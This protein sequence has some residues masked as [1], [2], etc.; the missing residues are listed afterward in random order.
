MAAA[1]R[2]RARGADPPR[3]RISPARRRATAAPPEALVPAQPCLICLD[4]AGTSRSACGHAFC[5]PCWEHYLEGR[6]SE[7][8]VLNMPCPASSHEPGVP[9]CPGVT[10]A[11]VA[12]V[13]PAAMLSRFDDFMV[14]E[15]AERDPQ[16]R[17]CTRPGCGSICLPWVVED[18]FSWR[19]VAA[20]IL[21]STAA[22]A[23]PLR[24]PALCTA[25]RLTPWVAAGTCALGVLGFIAAL[26]HGRRRLGPRRRCVCPTCG[27]SICYDCK[28]P[29]HPN[30]MCE[31]VLATS[32][33]R[34]CKVSSTPPSFITSV[35][36]RAACALASSPVCRGPRRP[37]CRQHHSRI[38][39]PASQPHRAPWPYRQHGIRQHHGTRRG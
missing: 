4:A 28:S 38:A 25:L 21:A 5:P 27:D 37:A 29:W 36:A 24:S 26:W 9:P 6:I 23:V 20:C 2:S 18:S 16:T 1:T 7:R 39:S 13:M 8:A 3:P 31:E 34:W 19:A 33:V 30:T 11:E 22:A 35:P 15:R 14:A 10:R 32:L 12:A 17:W